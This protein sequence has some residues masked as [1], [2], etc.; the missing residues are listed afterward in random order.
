MVTFSVN[1]DEGVRER[2]WLYTAFRFREKVRPGFPK[3]VKYIFA[4]TIKKY[5]G[6]KNTA[7]L[8]KQLV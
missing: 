4:K 3:I 2:H 1:Q 5:L 6:K 8:Q 7:A